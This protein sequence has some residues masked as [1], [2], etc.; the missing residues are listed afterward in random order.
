MSDVPFRSTMDGDSIPVP[1]EVRN[2]FDIEDGTVV[3]ASILLNSG[4]VSPDEDVRGTL[5]DKRATFLTFDALERQVVAAVRADEME[6][7]AETVDTLFL[8]QSSV[9]EWSDEYHEASQEFEVDERAIGE[10][11]ESVYDWAVTNDHSV[12]EWFEK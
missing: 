6:V 3:T 11:M 10:A 4:G 7:A 12:R 9:P 8:I 5:L 1:E 2:T